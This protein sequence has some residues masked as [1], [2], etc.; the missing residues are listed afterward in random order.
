MDM[1]QMPMGKMSMGDM[2]NSFW[3]DDQV[4]VVFHS[5]IPLIK[6]GILN[7]EPLQKLPLRAQ[8]EK[9]NRFLQEKGLPITLHFL[10]DGDHSDPN[11]P[12]PPQPPSTVERSELAD[13]LQ[14]PPGIFPFG[15]PTPIESSFGLIRTSV[16]SFFQI[17]KHSSNGGSGSTSMAMSGSGAD[18]DDNGESDST[19]NLVP[20]IVRTLNEN[21]EELNGGEHIPIT[22]AAPNLFRLLRYQ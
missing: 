2:H 21:L 17:K 14:L 11:P 5:D 19:G 22:I 6:D 20:L 7:K 15:F 4:M 10:H 9:L 3:R 12:V 13:G 8:L 1:Q 16:V 18:D